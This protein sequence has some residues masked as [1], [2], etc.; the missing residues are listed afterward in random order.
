MASTTTSTQL[1]PTQPASVTT[2]TTS[3]PKPGYKTSEFWLSL[4]ATILGV[5][6]TSGVIATGSIYDHAV[7]AA[8]TLL[9]ALGYTYNR[10][11]AKS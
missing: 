11:Q 7:G 10:T 2:V 6:M 4:A 5:L 8:V 3:D 9:A 1:T